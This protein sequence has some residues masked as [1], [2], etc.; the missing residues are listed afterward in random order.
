[1]GGEV[2][3]VETGVRHVAATATGDAYLGEKLLAF[4]Q[5]HD[6]CARQ[7]LGAGDG[8]EKTRGPTANDHQP[9]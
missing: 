4:L 6:F 3:R 8:R 5:H 7:R 2:A 1:M 9:S